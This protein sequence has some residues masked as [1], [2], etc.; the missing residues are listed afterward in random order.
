MPAVK[1]SIALLRH[2]VTREAMSY[3]IPAETAT[4][5]ADA[6]VRLIKDATQEK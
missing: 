5:I 6:V 1:I 2:Q 4:M 3:G